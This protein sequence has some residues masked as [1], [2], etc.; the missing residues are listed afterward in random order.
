[1]ILS[2]NPS[3]SGMNHGSGYIPSL[4]DFQVHNMN[5]GMPPTMGSPSG[6]QPPGNI[7]HALGALPVPGPLPIPVVPPAHGALPPPGGLLSPGKYIYQLA[8]YISA[9]IN[10]FKK[11][12]LLF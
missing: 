5:I 10:V 8:P 7:P 11:Q 4:L 12:I 1:M 2:D 6:V 9:C 3:S